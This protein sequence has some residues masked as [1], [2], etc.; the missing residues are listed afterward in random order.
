MKNEFTPETK[1]LFNESGLKCWFCGNV[2]RRD[3][4][5]FSQEVSAFHHILG[6]ISN[7]PLNCSPIHNE[8]CHLYNYKLQSFEEKS[9]LL[10]KTIRFLL[11]R[12]Y[13]LTEKDIEFYNNNI[14]YYG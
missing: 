1:A 5:G 11:K 13:C 4:F 6:R 3:K 8:G 10:K 2:L 9:K 14:D 7:S 12:D